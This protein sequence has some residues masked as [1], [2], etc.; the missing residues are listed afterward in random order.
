MYEDGWAETPSKLH[1]VMNAHKEGAQIGNKWTIFAWID[2]YIVVV[3]F[4]ID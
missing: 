1:K 3:N 2:E 4:F